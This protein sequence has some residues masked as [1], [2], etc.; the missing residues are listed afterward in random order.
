MVEVNH[1]VDGFR[2][3][4]GGEWNGSPYRSLLQF[5]LP[6]LGITAS[7]NAEPDGHRYVISVGR[8]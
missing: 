4:E 8:Q 3:R 6:A 5:P 1:P 7:F 2:L